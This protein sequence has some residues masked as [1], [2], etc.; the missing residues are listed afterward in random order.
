MAIE[1]GERMDPWAPLV[2]VVG[3]ALLLARTLVL[4]APQASGALAAVYLSIAA[5]AIVTPSPRRV[6]TSSMPP[7]LV[8]AIGGTA[9]AATPLVAGSP[10]PSSFGPLAVPLGVLAAVAEEALFRKVLYGWLE[11]YGP[12]VAIAA[13]AI[14]FAIAHVPLYGVSALPL[15]LGAGLLLSWQ[16]RASG[17]WTIPAA[18]HAAANLLVVIR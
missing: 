7:W 15:D 17:T 8:L 5:A 16:R 12:L 1:L 10:V 3:I 6:G 18:T 13:S 2:V 11:R 14:L 9:V 4:G